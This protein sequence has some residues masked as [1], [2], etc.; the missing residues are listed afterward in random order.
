MNSVCL[1]A[2]T[3]AGSFQGR[4]LVGRN[5]TKTAQEILES[6]VTVVDRLYV[7]GTTYSLPD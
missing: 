1:A 2:Q 7:N 6:T 3:S 5:A 4:Y